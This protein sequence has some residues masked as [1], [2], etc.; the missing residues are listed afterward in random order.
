MSL[1]SVALKCLG[2]GA[3]MRD[4]QEK[5]RRDG[6]QPVLVRYLGHEF[7]LDRRHARCIDLWVTDG[8]I[9]QYDLAVEYGDLA[10]TMGEGVP[11]SSWGSSIC[12]WTR[13]RAHSLPSSVRAITTHTIKVLKTVSSQ[14]LQSIRDDLISKEGDHEPGLETPPLIVCVSNFIVQHADIG[15]PQVQHAGGLHRE[16][17]GSRWAIGDRAACTV[18]SSLPPPEIEKACLKRLN[19]SGGS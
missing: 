13:N 14:T 4:V 17:S 1:T 10:S 18:Q 15:R 5:V 19:R 16:H 8:H 7:E 3:D 12:I 6:R 9:D 11:T 2:T